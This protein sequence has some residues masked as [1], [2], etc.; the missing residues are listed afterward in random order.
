MTGPLDFDRLSADYASGLVDTLRG[1]G[2]GAEILELW[3]ADE[4]PTTSLVN[5][6]DAAQ[7]AGRDSLSVRLGA[8]SA[9][10]L[11]RPRL[12]RDGG[13]Y[14]TLS[15]AEGDGLVVTVTG[16]H[17]I[18]IAVETGGAA[19]ADRPPEITETDAAETLVQP[20]TLHPAYLAGLKAIAPAGEEKG[21][22]LQGQA[23]GLTLTLWVAD[24]VINKAAVTGATTDIADRLTQAFCAEITG[25]PLLEAADH[26]SHRLARRLR[27]RGAAPPV[28]GVVTPRAA[29]P[30]FRLLDALIRDAAQVSGRNDF[31]EGPGPAWMSASDWERRERLAEVLVATAETL[32]IDP[33]GV[34]L[35]DIQHDVRVVIGFEGALARADRGRLLL[36]LE[37]GIKDRVDRRL[38]LFQRERKD[39]NVIRRLAEGQEDTGP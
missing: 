1:F 39:A 2:A 34:V 35:E 29:D 33:A 28:A 16:L 25:L 13:A 23:A 19:E 6:I 36:D 12:A 8:A 17:A 22:C 15:L 30:A 7:A 31:D 32:G 18:D 20:T 21:D 9:A 11:D 37:A 4:D 3:V 26:G 14:G 38:E 24:G 5:M 10:A 27:D